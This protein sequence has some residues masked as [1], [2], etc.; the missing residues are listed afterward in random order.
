ML[1]EPVKIAVSKGV[2]HMCNGVHFK[3]TNK[4]SDDY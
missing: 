3:N 4:S 2:D 1:S